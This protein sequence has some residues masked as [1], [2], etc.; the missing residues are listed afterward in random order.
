MRRC[1]GTYSEYN[2]EKNTWEEKEF[3]DGVF[4]QWGNNYEEF[5]SG[6]G[7]YTV[8]V[9]ELP[10]GKVVMTVASNI[11]FIKEEE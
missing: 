1:R 4:H 5:D 7:N 3:V 9:V 6:S 2:R 8:A 11:Q 10:D